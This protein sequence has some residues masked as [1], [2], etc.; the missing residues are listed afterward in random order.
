V[1]YSNALLIFLFVQ[2][3]ENSISN[4]SAGNISAFRTFQTI[5]NTYS[6]VLD[7]FGIKESVFKNT[8]IEHICNR[9]EHFAQ[10]VL[11]R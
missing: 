9:Y 10:T 2:W 1:Q 3:M 11:S 7:D 4:Y 6:T 5:V 8:V